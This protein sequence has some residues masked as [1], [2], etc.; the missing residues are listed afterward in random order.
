[1]TTYYAKRQIG[2]FLIV[3]FTLESPGLSAPLPEFPTQQQTPSATI[4]AA[5][6]QESRLA[7]QLEAS[8]ENRVELEKAINLAP[9]E[10]REAVKFLITHMPANDLQNLTADFLLTNV[11]LAYEARNN[12][13]WL[14]P[15]E[16]FLNDVLPY[17]NIDEPRD[18][19]RQTFSDLCWPLTV[20]IRNGTGAPAQSRTR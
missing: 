10:Q 19:W 6:E 12:A 5:G 8:G 1:M 20:V 2:L 16:I 9:A 18:P 7:K 17:A 14:I 15:D 4:D 3:L 11:R 13:P